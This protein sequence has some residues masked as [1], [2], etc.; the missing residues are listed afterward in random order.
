MQASYASM[1][2]ARILISARGP[3]RCK[4][5]QPGSYLIE[6]CRERITLPPECERLTCPG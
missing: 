6:N 2:K 4:V 1:D 5:G 3:K